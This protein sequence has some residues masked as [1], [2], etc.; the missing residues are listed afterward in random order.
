MTAATTHESD[1][2]LIATLDREN[3]AV[4]DCVW[5]QH[6]TSGEPSLHFTFSGKDFARLLE[7]AKRG[8]NIREATGEEAASAAGR[9]LNEAGDFRARLEREAS[10]LR[11]AAGFLEHMARHFMADAESVL[12]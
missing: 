5:V 10:K 11:G 4:P 6:T 7:L 1:E 2:A 9:V 12:A 8:L 3:K